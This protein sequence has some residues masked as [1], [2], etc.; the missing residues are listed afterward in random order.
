MLKT[1]YLYHKSNVSLASSWL[2]W[3]CLFKVTFVGFDIYWKHHTQ[4]QH[5]CFIPQWALVVH[6][7]ITLYDK[8]A[9]NTVGW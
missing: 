5:N 3:Q 2:R 1:F 9:Q 6:S 4:T 7:H 8:T